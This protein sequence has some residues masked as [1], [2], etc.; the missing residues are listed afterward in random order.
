MPQYGP[1]LRQKRLQHQ[2]ELQA[3][4]I[5]R[6]LSQHDASAR[7]VGGAVR[8]RAVQFDVQ[9]GL[10]Q[11]VER[12]KELKDEL[13]RALGGAMIHF[14][15]ENGRFNLEVTQSNNVPVPLLDLL[16]LLPEVPPLTVIL[17]LSEDGRPV[18]LN[19]GEEEM[20]HILIAGEEAA[21]KTSLLRTIALSLAMHNRQSRL[22][23]LVCQHA[24]GSATQLRP[25]DYL[26]HMLTGVSSTASESAQLFTFLCNEMDYRREQ[27][28][29]NPA[30]IVLVDGIETLLEEAATE[31]AGS[32]LTG[33]ITRLLQ[34]GA[35]VGIHLV[36]ATDRPMTQTIS[37]WLKAELPVRLVGKVPEAAISQA[38]TGVPDAQAEYLLG[39]GDFVA[40]SPAGVLRFQAAYLSDYDLHLI[41]EE[42]HRQRPPALLAQIAD[43]HTTLP[44]TETVVADQPFAFNGDEILLGSVPVGRRP[45]REIFVGEA[46]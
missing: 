11:G 16:P 17:G 24:S 20:T 43:A 2:L 3:R 12:L 29:C 31:L 14:A 19:F 44:E 34:R 15:P 36:L 18:L 26:P 22:Q 13:M 41:L 1:E 37:G 10:A 5:E 38:V 7:V 23:L 6:V 28:V 32:N 42:L 40:A 4:Q 33:C 30:I 25:L 9:A 39:S 35:E 45:E 21:G 46:K 8:P 27:K